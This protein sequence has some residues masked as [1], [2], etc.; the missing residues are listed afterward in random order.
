MGCEWHTDRMSRSG[1]LL[2]HFWW[3]LSSL[4]G[5]YTRVTYR[6]FAPV[7]H[8]EHSRSPSTLAWVCGPRVSWWT[9]GLL[10]APK[11]SPGSLLQSQIILVTFSVNWLD[12]SLFLLKRRIRFGNCC[13]PLHCSSTIG[14][15]FYIW[16]KDNATRTISMSYQHVSSLIIVGGREVCVDLL[17]R[18]VQ[19]SRRNII[20]IFNSRPYLQYI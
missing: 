6:Q 14:A 10:R 19:H 3:R 20:V 17:C 4:S 8:D 1:A 13:N 7:L 9:R 11:N 2:H 12:L 5:W 16:N 15:N 18:Q